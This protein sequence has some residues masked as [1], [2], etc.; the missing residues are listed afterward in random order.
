MVNQFIELERE[1]C[2]CQLFSIVKPKSRSTLSVP[3]EWSLRFIV[4]LPLVL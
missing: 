3:C 1:R 4:Y 2:L